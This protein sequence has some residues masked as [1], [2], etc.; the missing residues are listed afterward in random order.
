VRA[1][2]DHPLNSLGPTWAQP[3]ERPR[4]PGHLQTVAYAWS[5]QSNNAS[6]P[7]ESL[8]EQSL[9]RKVQSLKHNSADPGWFDRDR[10]ILSAGRAR[11]LL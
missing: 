10:V 11:M 1:P 4:V 3:P 7:A 2:C 5:R 6:G 8:A 9:V